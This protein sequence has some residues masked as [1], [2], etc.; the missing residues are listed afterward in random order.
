M[1]QQDNWWLAVAGLLAL[2]AFL[3]FL[4]GE[5]WGGTLAG[6]L[7]LMVVLTPTP[8]WFDG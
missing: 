1:K 7:G 4:A 3:C 5:P 8:E 2:G 6:G